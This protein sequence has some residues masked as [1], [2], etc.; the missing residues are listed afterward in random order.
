MIIRKKKEER[1]SHQAGTWAY[2]DSMSACDTCT[3]SRLYNQSPDLTPQPWT[4][5]V[6]PTPKE[7][8]LFDLSIG[9]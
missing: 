5:T 6:K 7:P 8:P 3:N 4:R 2:L 9:G 1:E